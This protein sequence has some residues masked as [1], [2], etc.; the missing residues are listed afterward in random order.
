[1]S[2]FS[3]AKGTAA[4]SVIAVFDVGSG[5][6][7]AALVYLS[8]TR[9]PNIIW[10]KRTPITFQETPEFEKLSKSMLSTLLDMALLLQSEGVPLLKQLDGPKRVSDVMFG[11][12]SPWYSMQAKVFKVE[13]EQE[14]EITENFIQSLIKK[15]EQ[16]F[17]KTPAGKEG[18]GSSA[19]VL[20][21]RQIIQT[22]LNGYVVSDPYNKPV[23]NAQIDLVLSAI[24]SYIYEKASDIRTQLV[25]KRSGGIFNSF[26]LPAF[27]VTRDVFHNNTNFLLIDVSAEVTD[28]VTVNKGT[29]IDATSFPHGKHTVIREVASKLGTVPEEAASMLA[30]YLEGNS[31]SVQAE[32]IKHILK[33]VQK[34]WLLHFTETLEKISRDAPLPKHVFL[35]VDD[36]YGE[37]F[38]RVIAAGDF[39]EF[40]L[41]KTP[42]KITVLSA[43]VLA[44][45][46]DHSKLTAELDPF[47]AIET[48]FLQKLLYEQDTF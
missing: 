21:E 37:W 19:P 13:K 38:K 7:G 2:L 46:C 47:L 8:R 9:L 5:S 30:G 45:Y 29:I 48:L 39:S 40:A 15:E 41:S 43:D 25:H 16:E 44:Q 20:I 42:F 12:A 4:G 35:T 18:G 17:R 34:T 28:L 14:F 36:D 10:T 27:I 24:P 3:S 1:M 33:E 23:K 32:E 31:T 22:S 11:F 6:V 26:I